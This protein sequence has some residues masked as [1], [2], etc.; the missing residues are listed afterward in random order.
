MQHALLIINPHSRNGQVEALE[1]AVR[2]LEV[3]GIE[4]SV[5]ESESEAHLVSLIEE[6]DREDGIVIIGD[7]DGTIS[8]ALEALHTRQRTLAIFPMGTATDFARSIGVPEPL[9]AAA[10]VIVDGKREQISLA[11]INNEHFF[12]NVAHVGLG[13]DVTRELTSDSKKFFGVFAYL[14]AFFK[15]IKR[16]KSFKVHIKTD[17]WQISTR[18]IHLAIGNGRFYGGGNIVDQRSTL[19]EGKL[20]LFF[21]KP[22]RWW[23]L[24][25][26]GPKLRIG[27]MDT[28]DRIVRKASDKFSIQTSRP[29]SVEADGEFK[30]TTPVEFEVIPK[31]IEAIVG[32][33]P[34]STSGTV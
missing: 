1:E 16:N 22:Q 21:I 19:L 3:S 4:V 20:N 15:A 25:L 34:T 14:G 9:L 30:T 7:G 28:T 32:D 23:Q 27:A 24:L 10:Q 13:V 33:I 18:A 31:A 8:S 6:Y 29:K 11:K 12:I 5:C 2:F 17:D 26:L